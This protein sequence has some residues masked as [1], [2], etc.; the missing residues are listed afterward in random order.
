MK[1]IIYSGFDATVNTTIIILSGISSGSPFEDIF[2]I[3]MAAIIAG[4]LDMACCDYVSCKAEISF[5]KMEEEREM[6]EV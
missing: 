4:A 1:S 6:Y 2:A 5:I 3:S